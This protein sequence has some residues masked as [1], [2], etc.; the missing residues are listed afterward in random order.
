MIADPV[1]AYRLADDTTAFDRAQVVAHGAANVMWPRALGTTPWGIS[2]TLNVHSGAFGARYGWYPTDP[3]RAE[4]IHRALAAAVRAAVHGW[5]VPLLIGRWEP[6]HWVLV[7]DG[8]ADSLRCYEP[9][10][11]RVVDVWV[12]EVANRRAHPLGFPDL[13]AVVLPRARLDT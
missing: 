7:L 9:S 8:T 3:A 2:A 5:P 10:G 4:D 13:H 12:D 1:Y 11:G 6:R